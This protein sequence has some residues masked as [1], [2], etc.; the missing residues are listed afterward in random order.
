MDNASVVKNV[1][2]FFDHD[3]TIIAIHKIVGPWARHTITIRHQVRHIA[4][5]ALGLLL[6]LNYQLAFRAS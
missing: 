3:I 5:A 2:A 4:L 6:Y 1:G